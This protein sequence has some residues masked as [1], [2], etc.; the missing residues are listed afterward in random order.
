MKLKSISEPGGVKLLI[1]GQPKVGKTSLLLTL[2]EDN[3]LF[4]DLEAGDL[5]V[6][7]WAGDSVAPQTWEELRDLACWFGGANPAYR[8]EQNYSNEHYNAL[9]QSHEFDDI[10][11]AKYQTLFIDSLSVAARLCLQYCKGQPQAFS[12]KTGKPNLLG[13]YGLLGQELIGWVTQL[14]HI[15]PVNLVFV[16]L[17]DQKLDEYN[18]PFWTLQIEGQKAGLEIPGIVDQIVS[19]VEMPVEVEGGNKAGT[20]PEMVRAFVC[21]R[22]N[23]WGYPAGD[24]SGKLEMIER[25]HLGQLLNKIKTGTRKVNYEY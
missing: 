4:I 15:R 24:R 20:P 21:T 13:A 8:P 5:A 23:S 2:P 16:C 12:E 25:P 14:Q 10:N 1:T 18:R 17:L 3:T 6:Q 22:P 11:K 9:V 19:M 7:G